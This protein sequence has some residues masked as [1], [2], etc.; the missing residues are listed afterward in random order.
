[1][2]DC[3]LNLIK[4]N[5]QLSFVLKR[6]VWNVY[7]KLYLLVELRHLVIFISDVASLKKR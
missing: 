4:N 1:M 6:H 5:I 3:I 7:V 2:A